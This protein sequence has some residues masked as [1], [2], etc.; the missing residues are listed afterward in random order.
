MLIE[1]NDVVD[2]TTFPG[3]PPWYSKE[4]HYFDNNKRYKNNAD[5]FY[6]HYPAAGEQPTLL[7]AVEST[8]VLDIPR[9]PHRIY[10]TYP[11]GLRRHLQF[12]VVLRDPIDRFSSWFCHV[13]RAGL[14][15]KENPE[16][17]ANNGNGMGQHWMSLEKKGIADD[18][19]LAKRGMAR[20]RWCKHNDKKA[21]NTIPR[22]AWANMHSCVRKRDGG[23]LIAGL[24]FDQLYM[25]TSVFDVS[26]FSVVT[27]SDIKERPAETMRFL[28][29][30]VGARQPPE[31]RNFSWEDSSR[32]V[33]PTNARSSAD[34]CPESVPENILPELKEFFAKHNDALADWLEDELLAHGWTM[35]STVEEIRRWNTFLKTEPTNKSGF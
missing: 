13:K 8:P 33:T 16:N 23:G 1:Y 6:R 22:E 24:Y 31:F 2:A 10:E 34:G 20:W 5:F 28:A 32:V 29:D 14:Q 9:V 26:Q 3:E 12:V 35:P 4:Q 19:I 21:K 18:G 27:L 7:Q 30:R 11:P 17:V 25:W 15:L